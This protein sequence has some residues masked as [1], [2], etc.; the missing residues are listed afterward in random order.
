[1]GV[2]AVGGTQRG[3]GVC[4]CGWW[5]CGVGVVYFFAVAPIT[6]APMPFTCCPE[7]VMLV[8]GGGLVR[9]RSRDADLFFHL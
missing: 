5:V 3:L 2:G 6:G 4:C 9:R 7:F 8:V 1:V